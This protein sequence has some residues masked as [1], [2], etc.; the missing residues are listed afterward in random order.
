MSLLVYN[1]VC[2][3]I[4]PEFIRTKENSKKNYTQNKKISQIT[5][6]RLIVGIDIAKDKHVAQAK[7]DRG[8]GPIFENHIRLSETVGLGLSSIKVKI[9]TNWLTSGNL[10][11]FP[12]AKE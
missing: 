8:I 3:H 2:R 4:D 9:R 6:E 5:L 11:Q 7:D 12:V 10:S 1:T